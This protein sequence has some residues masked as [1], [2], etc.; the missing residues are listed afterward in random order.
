MNHEMNL[1]DA[2]F[3]L[4]KN[5]TKTIELRLNDERRKDLKSGD[6][7]TFT[8]RSTLETLKVKVLNVYKYDN[9]TELYKH[10]DKVSMGYSINDIPNPHDMDIYYTKEHQAL[11]GVIAIEIEVI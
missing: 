5:R 2:P 3:N 9:F 7:I 6:T 11:Y 8:N 1:H 4:I 10:H